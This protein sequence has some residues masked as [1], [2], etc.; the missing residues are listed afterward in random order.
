MIYTHKMKRDATNLN[1]RRN[2][3]IIPRKIATTA[4]ATVLT[5]SAGLG[6]TGCFGISGSSSSSS[7]SGDTQVDSNTAKMVTS[8][9]K[10]TMKKGSENKMFN[11]SITLSV[12]DFQRRP[13]SLFQGSS[14]QSSDAGS[15]SGTVGT[16]STDDV[17]LQID[18]SY[19]WN[20]N[21]YS[22][23]TTNAGGTNTTAPSTLEDVL[24]PGKL[25]YIQGKDQYGE[26]YTT[27]T[28]ITPDTT[29]D[30]TLSLN[31]QWDYN[32][33]KGDLPQASDTKK[34]SI[35]FQVSTNVT[36][37]E[38]IIITPDNNPSPTQADSVLSGSNK[39]Y[40]IDLT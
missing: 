34:G 22:T 30:N 19:M 20:P 12:L 9:T 38:L 7:S 14:T 11:N 17:A 27:S 24:Q 4:L 16:T 23:N 2:N 40:S 6:L 32:L 29:E 5:V 28:I 35:V 8:S 15:S 3:K 31:Q 37:L 21:T 10:I 26:L 1:A 13:V 25:M 36:D 18:F 33:L 39:I